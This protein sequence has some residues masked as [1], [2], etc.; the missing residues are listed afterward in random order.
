MKKLFLTLIVAFSISCA[1]AQAEMDFPFQGGK[2]VMYDYFADNI[3][4]TDLIKQKAATGL[5]MV[6]FTSDEKGSIVKMVIYYADDASLAEPIVKAL[7]ATNGRWIVPAGQKT[8]DF[9]IPFSINITV[10]DDKASAAMLQYYN[11]RQP[12]VAT[13]LVPLDMVSLLPIVQVKYS[14]EP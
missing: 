12:I 10:A 2:K 9:I 5:V 1:M 8:Y 14:L 7:K 6:K 11:T 13:N 4:V 3:K